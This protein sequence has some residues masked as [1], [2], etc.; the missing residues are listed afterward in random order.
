MHKTDKTISCKI[1]IIGD[2]EW[3]VEIDKILKNHDKVEIAYGKIH[4]VNSA[5]PT[6]A[7]LYFWQRRIGNQCIFTKTLKH[8]ARV[9]DMSGAYRLPV[10][11]FEKWYGT[12]HQAP[13]LIKDAV[14]GMPALFADKIAKARLVASQAATPS[15]ILALLLW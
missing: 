7:T 12:E 6:A 2:T 5:A 1:G 4:P 10:N 8:G 11:L 13:D 9:I 15:V 14:Y 3:S